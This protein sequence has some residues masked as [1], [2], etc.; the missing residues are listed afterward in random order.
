L[1]FE[2]KDLRFLLNF[3]H[4]VCNIVQG[5]SIPPDGRRLTGL[6]TD[7]ATTAFRWHAGRTKG[8]PVHP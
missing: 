2:L 1:K 4:A 5:A 8:L 6:R 3:C 7:T